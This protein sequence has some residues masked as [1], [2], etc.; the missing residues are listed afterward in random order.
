MEWGD[1]IQVTR[2]EDVD[3]SVDLLAAQIKESFPHLEHFDEKK[4][5]SIGWKIIQV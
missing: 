2:K 4:S 3:M 1:Y 5:F